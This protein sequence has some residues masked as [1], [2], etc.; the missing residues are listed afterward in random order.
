MGASIQGNSFAG[1]VMCC[2]SLGEH[3]SI[4]PLSF[5]ARTESIDESLLLLNPVSFSQVRASEKD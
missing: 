4:L 1:H 5:A 2:N 3:T